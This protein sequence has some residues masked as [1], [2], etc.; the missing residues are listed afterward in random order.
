[1]KKAV[2]CILLFVCIQS[3]CSNDTLEQRDKLAN[4]IE[5]NEYSGVK[6]EEKP[7][8]QETYGHTLN[9]ANADK[10]EVQP[11][12]EGTCV[13]TINENNYDLANQKEK[14]LLW[15]GFL[16][17][18]T[19]VLYLDLYNKYFIDIKEVDFTNGYYEISST[20]LVPKMFAEKIY[21]MSED[22]KKI[23]LV[24]YEDGINIIEIIDIIS[25]SVVYKK[26]IH[27]SINT[28]WISSSPNLEHLLIPTGTQMVFV[29]VKQHKESITDCKGVISPDGK[30]SAFITYEGNET[31][32]K[33]SDILTSKIVE[34]VDL[35]IGK[36]YITQWHNSDKILYYT[37][38]GSFIYDFITKETKKV[39]EYLYGPQMS[40]DERYIAFHRDDD[41][42]GFCPLYN[43]NYMLYKEN[44]FDNGLYILDL[45]TNDLKKIAPLV[46]NDFS[47]Y[48]QYP[49]QWVYVNKDFDNEK[50]R[51]CMSIEN[52]SPFAV[53]SSSYKNDYD[54]N[55]VLDKDPITAWAE[56]EERYDSLKKYSGEGKDEWLLIFKQSKVTV[57]APL[58]NCRAGYLEPISLSGIKIVNGYAK[59]EEVYYLNNRVKKVEVILS[60]GTSLVYELNDDTMDFQTLDFGRV[61]KTR[62]VVVKIHDVYKGSKY[63]DTCISEIQLIEAG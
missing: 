15:V 56:D 19:E 36:A 18:S 51:C 23:L 46:Y 52:E 29:D 14:Y 21:K 57:E 9:G 20:S 38:A 60:D 33:I 11:T 47:Q 3:G 31:K 28:A 44:G 8:D 59:N 42:D 62:S 7:I 58:Q 34:S 4:V 10:G 49:V 16:P 17:L 12:I 63:N 45:L 53:W 25:H 48:V 1:M 5:N 55:N 13:Y 41:I 26:E 43:E 50:Y 35:A 27:E 6:E 24:Y 22:G 39:G 61:I 40:P 30:K 37:Y 54:P 32:L 2:I